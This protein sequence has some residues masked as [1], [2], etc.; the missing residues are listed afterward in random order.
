MSY[1]NTKGD[2]ASKLKKN[3]WTF[4]HFFKEVTGYKMEKY[5]CIMCC[6]RHSRRLAKW[7]Q[8]F[9]GTQRSCTDLYKVLRTTF[10]LNWL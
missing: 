1:T 6:D 4:I 2:L 9:R 3:V 10:Q 8:I 5:D 7:D